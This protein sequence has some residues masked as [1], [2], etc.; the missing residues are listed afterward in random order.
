MISFITQSAIANA[1]SLLA[2]TK[3]KYKID[4]SPS[5][6]CFS[7]FVPGSHDD[8]L[9]S[10]NKIAFLL[11]SRDFLLH[12]NNQ[13]TSTSWRSASHN[14]V[15]SNR[16]ENYDLMSSLVALL[17]GGTLYGDERRALER[18]SPTGSLLI[19]RQGQ[20]LSW[21]QNPTRKQGHAVG[22]WLLQCRLP[23][24]MKAQESDCK[25]GWPVSWGGSSLYILFLLQRSRPSYY[26]SLEINSATYAQDTQ[27]I[28]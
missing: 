3:Y 21:L 2:S 22:V 9:P 27:S 11:S 15:L 10:S 8:A 6:C 19:P 18:L 4:F 20:M 26:T 1:D 23:I 17:L 13:E 28:I 5:V 12:L 14:S 25:A 7:S 16:R 24:E